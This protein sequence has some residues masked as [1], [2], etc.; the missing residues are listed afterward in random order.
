MKTNIEPGKMQVAYFSLEIALENSLKSYAGGLGVLAGD[1]LRAAADS[2]QP[3]V[4]IS[5][6]NDQGYFKQSFNATGEQI[7]APITDYD[8][9]KLQLLP[10]EA[11][12]VIGDEQV[13]VRAWQYRLFGSNGAIVPVVLLDTNYAG[14]PS[15]YRSLTRQLYSGGSDERLQ[16]KIILGR[17]GLKMLQALGYNNLKKIHLNEGHGALAAV[18][19]FLNNAAGQDG[20]ARLADTRRHCVFTTHTPVKEAI[21]IYPLN[22]FLKLQPDFPYE[23]PG[24]VED[25][26]VNMAAVSLYFSGYSN[27]V[28]RAHQRTTQA[29]FPNYKIEAI[30]NGVHSATWTAPEFQALYDLHI[31]GWRD[32]GVLLKQASKLALAD[33][34]RAHLSTKSRLLDY[35][36]QKTGRKL[37]AKTLT[38]GLARRFT[39]YKRLGLLFTNLPRLLEI[40]KIAGKMQIVCAGKAHPSDR[41]GQETILKIQQ[42]SRKYVDDLSVV[43]LEDYDLEQARLITAGTDVLLNTPL[44]PFEA[45]GTSGIKAA[46]NGVLQISTW[47]GWWPEGYVLDQTGWTISAPIEAAVTGLTGQASL[48]A[49]NKSASVKKRDE[50]DA[51]SLYGLLETKVLPT[52]YQ[53]AEKWM[54]MMRAAIAINAA[55]FNM[56]RVL[57]QYRD[58]AYGL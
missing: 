40:Q 23:L 3:F 22:E 49:A 12:V 24:L 27:A 54:K 30:T 53:Q 13:K 5:L 36:Y 45:S 9:T 46:H 6:L 16:Q 34:S 42:I 50:E 26:H 58:E 31:P 41:S 2:G 14:N 1:L 18:E 11:I 8:Y 43:F 37:S 29:M 56:N 15:K 44:P 4:G 57:Q 19:F 25:Q 39:Q 21:N 55:A 33:L 28:S 48:I 7:T 32:D 35:I 52:Y 17:G 20:A 51:E 10:A 38:I 47:D